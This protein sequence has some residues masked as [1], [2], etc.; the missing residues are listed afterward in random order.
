MLRLETIRSAFSVNFC[1]ILYLVHYIS[2]HFE[3]HKQFIKNIH[4][5]SE[6]WYKSFST[7][8]DSWKYFSKVNYPTKTEVE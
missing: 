2:K 8:R 3:M 5:N 4:G 7:T 1:V 6:V